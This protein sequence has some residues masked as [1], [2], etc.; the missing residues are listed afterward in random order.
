MPSAAEKRRRQKEERAARREAARKAAARRELLRRIRAALGL[1]VA[2]AAGLLLIGYLSRRQPSL[3]ATYLEYRKQ[4]TACDAEPPPPLTPMSFQAPEDQGLS[5]DDEITAV[6]TTSC[7]EVV[8]RLDPA[9]APQTVNSFV[10]LARAGFYDGT[11]FHRVVPDFVIQ[12]GDPEA[13]GSGGPGYQLPDE[14]P[15]SDFVYRPGVVAMYNSGRGTT[16]SQFFIV[17]GDKAQALNPTF[18]LLGEVIAGTDTLQRI[19]RVPLTRQAA[20]VEE[21]RPLETVY[22]EKVEIRVG[23]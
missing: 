18:N 20:T 23:N 3:P 16:G 14:P 8:V 12:G 1:G 4:P 7:G 10:F 5:P 19:S 9:A 15:P 11:V 21:S 2:V 13:T 6:L 22:L 17:V